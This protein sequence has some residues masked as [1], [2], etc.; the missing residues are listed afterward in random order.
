MQESEFQPYRK[1]SKI[2]NFIQHSFISIGIGLVFVFF[3]Y[4][5]MWLWSGDKDGR[6]AIKYGIIILVVSY[7]CTWIACIAWKCSNKL[8]IVILQ[9]FSS[10]SD[11]LNFA[12]NKNSKE[13]VKIILCAI[14]NAA[15]YFT[16]IIAIFF[17]ISGATPLDGLEIDDD[18]DDEYTAKN[19]TDTTNKRNQKKLK[20]KLEEEF[21]KEVKHPNLV[22]DHR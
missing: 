3:I 15:I 7:I 8:D 14:F 6:W 21:E 22:Y 18:D 11:L 2:F 9:K 19:P 20:E 4:L 17:I 16:I 5:G 12:V 10:R 13:N 1:K